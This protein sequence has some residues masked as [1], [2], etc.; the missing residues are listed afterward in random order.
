MK[1]VPPP[2]KL[3]KTTRKQRQSSSDYYYRNR[4]N[5]NAGARLK[6]RQRRR[7]LGLPTWG[8][9]RTIN[10][11]GYV[12]IRVGPAGHR[13]AV[14]EHRDI[15]ERHTGWPL[16]EKVVH[17]IDGIRDHNAIENLQIMTRQE[18]SAKLTVEEVKAIKTS[19]LRAKPL[20]TKYNVSVSAIY[21]IRNGKTWKSI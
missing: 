14:L 2:E 4:R 10:K 21:S 3:F 16:G 1:T 19:Q 11:D 5:I 18:H 13:H 12:T 9:A 8:Y 6:R 20:A 15:M 17:H 7:A